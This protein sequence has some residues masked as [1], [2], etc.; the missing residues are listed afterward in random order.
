MSK[1]GYTEIHTIPSTSVY[2]ALLYTL[3]GAVMLPGLGTL[4]LSPKIYE[5]FSLKTRG[6]PFLISSRFLTESLICRMPS[7]SHTG[8]GNVVVVLASVLS[9]TNRITFYVFGL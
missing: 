1:Y 8:V 5:I 4:T 6:I 2:R 3:Q 7:I 9:Y